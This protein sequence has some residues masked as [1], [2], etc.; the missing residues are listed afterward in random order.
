MRG[1]VLFGN[2]Y[3]VG[4]LHSRRILSAKTNHL[5]G[6]NLLAHN[7]LHHE[8][9]R[10]RAIRPQRF[11]LIASQRSK[12]RVHGYENRER[13]P[14]STGCSTPTTSERRRKF[15]RRRLCRRP[16][17]RRWGRRWRQLFLDE[18]ATLGE[19]LGEY[20]ESRGCVRAEACRSWQLVV[21]QLKH[22]F[23]LRDK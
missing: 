23:L 4:L 13:Q 15:A 10:A 5:I 7:I 1:C 22:S 2:G 9:V 12:R 3:E 11:D 8:F 17:R 14:I 16:Y 18:I 19:Y 21:E 20:G 6:T